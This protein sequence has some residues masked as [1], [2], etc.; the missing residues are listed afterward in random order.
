M[1]DQLAV[2]AV[3]LGQGELQHDL[4]AV[5]HAFELLG[6]GRLQQL[7]GLG[8]ASGVN[9]DLG[10]DD[11]HQPGRQDPPADVEL[12]GGH[13]LHARGVG[14]CDHRAHLGAEHAGRARPLQQ[15]VEPGHRLHH[16]GVVGSLGEPLVDLEERH[17]RLVLPQVSR[18][19]PAVDGSVHGHLEEDRPDDPVAAE[20]GGRADAAAHGVDQVEHLGLAVVVGLVDPV[21]AQ[22]LGGAA[23]A[24]VEGGDEAVA[25]ADL[26]EHL[27]VHAPKTR[28]A[29]M[30][31]AAGSQAGAPQ[32]AEP[33]QRSPEALLRTGRW[34]SPGRSA[35]GRSA[36]RCA[37]RSCRGSQPHGRP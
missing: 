15:R 9:I 35:A 7:L 13:R 1:L 23:A 2:K 14:G 12:L 19:G 11:R 17:H 8:L 31:P 28:P 4:V 10:L 22:R 18:R 37:W 26:V 20:R 3:G 6:D 27:S 21:E 30:A 24:L 25:A 34:R 36:R 16:L 32:P 5:G 29:G 33:Q